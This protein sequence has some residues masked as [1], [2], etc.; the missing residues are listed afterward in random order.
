MIAVVISH[1]GGDKQKSRYRCYNLEELIS[2]SSFSET[3][4]RDR[5]HKHMWSVKSH[6]VG[7]M[8]SQANYYV[9]CVIV[10]L[11]SQNNIQQILPL[12]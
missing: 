9:C 3:S 7:H 12:F 1:L 6:V 8:S 11:M 2:N 4:Y 5:H 10:R